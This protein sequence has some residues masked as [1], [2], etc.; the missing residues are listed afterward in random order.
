MRPGSPVRGLR[1]GAVRD[2]ESQA[3]RN[4]YPDGLPE[5]WKLPFYSHYWKDLLFPAGDWAR[6]VRETGWL[7]D[8]P[9]D[10]RLYF[11]LPSLPDDDPTPCGLL[12]EALEQRLGGF[13]LPADAEPPVGLGA[14]P[15]FRCENGPQLPGALQ[16]ARFAGPGGVVLVLEPEPD[17][18]L[19]R[20]RGLLESAA[21]LLADARQP[22]FLRAGPGELE[23]AE[24][25]LRLSGL[26]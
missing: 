26:G 20:W 8:V 21:G 5:D 22:V 10:L 16:V 3:W 23:N 1:L 12:A 13:L 14:L 6:A 15:V 4:F 18:T 7:V 24:T 19:A 2:D 11:E 9:R 25:I 17:L